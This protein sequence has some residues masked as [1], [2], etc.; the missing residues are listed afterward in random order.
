MSDSLKK[1]I[2]RVYS[3]GI[4]QELINKSILFHDALLGGP[5]INGNIIV[6][7]LSSTNN[8]ERQIIRANYKGIF[9]Y[10]IQN[11]IHSQLSDNNIFHD[12][13]LSMFDTPYEYDARELRKAFSTSLE[14]DENIINEIFVSRPKHY[15][16]MIDL[17][18]KN[19]FEISLR[20]ELQKNLSKKYSEFL[21]ALMDNDR[22]S[23]ETISKKEAY[24]IVKD[25]SKNGIKVY[26]NDLNLFKKFFIL[27]SRKDLIMISR[28]YYEINKVY[29]F[30]DILKE[31]LDEKNINKFEEKE[32]NKNIRL[33][34]DLL[35]AVITPAQFFAKKCAESLKD[36]IN[37]INTLIRILISRAEID[38]KILR[39][40]YYKE[41][42]KDIKKD[43][44][45]YSNLKENK[46]V[47]LILTNIFKTV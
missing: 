28:A 4:I 32:I 17:A 36:E 11:D 43:I 9:K 7:I 37:D 46:N 45:E 24:E 33:I 2:T 23:E 22:P 1:S 29:L 35:F 12:I 15:L 25:L 40:Y 20:E 6:D 39:D 3:P 21:L 13:T 16:E 27:K 42:K 10:P 5:K 30:D 19:F 38:I 34:K 44:K 14:K 47:K 26:A 31:V 8:E 41:T 18:Y